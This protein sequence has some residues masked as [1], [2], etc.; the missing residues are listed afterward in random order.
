MPQHI[1][2]ALTIALPAHWPRRTLFPPNSRLPGRALTSLRTGT[3][4]SSLGTVLSRDARWPTGSRDTRLTLVVFRNWNIQVVLLAVFVVFGVVKYGIASER[5]THNRPKRFLLF[6][7]TEYSLF[8]QENLRRY[9]PFFFA[10]I[11]SAIQRWKK[12]C[13]HA[14]RIYLLSN[15]GK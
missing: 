1:K 14:Q 5:S 11:Y 15:I 3:A 4:G 12:R 9:C 6:S 8:V 10:A 7:R 13:I 2:H